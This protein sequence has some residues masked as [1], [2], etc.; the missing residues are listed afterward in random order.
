MLSALP[1]IYISTATRGLIQ[2]NTINILLLVIRMASTPKGIHLDAFLKGSGEKPP[3]LINVHAKYESPAIL[4][5]V[6]RC[7]I[8]VGHDL[9]LHY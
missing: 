6:K 8:L 9:G 5:S 2:Y 1:N 7:I 4:I 3:Y